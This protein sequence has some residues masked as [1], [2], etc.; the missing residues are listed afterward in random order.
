ML[1][2]MLPARDS[3]RKAK[4]FQ[5]ALVDQELPADGKAELGWVQSRKEWV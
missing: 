1:L 2:I 4:A 5:Q 3:G